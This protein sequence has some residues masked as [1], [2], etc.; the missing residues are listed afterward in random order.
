MQKE[1]TDKNIWQYLS[2]AKR[3]C[4]NKVKTQSGV[5]TVKKFVKKLQI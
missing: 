2:R 1:N 5:E 3:K 4:E